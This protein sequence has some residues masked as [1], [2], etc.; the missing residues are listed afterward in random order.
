V[1]RQAGSAT[2]T[3]MSTQTTIGIIGTGISG[4]HLA[5][6]L[7][8]A[9]MGTTVYAAHAPDV[10]AAGRP[11]S[12]MTRFEQTR[13]RERS[14]GVAHW[15]APDHGVFA[16][17]IDVLGQQPLS[18][19][20][21]PRRPASRVDFR[22]Y[23]PKLLADYIARGGSTVVGRVDLD[24]LADRHDLIVIAAGSASLPRLFPCDLAR[25]PYDRPQRR[26]CAGLFH[27]IAPT[28]S[29][30]LRIQLSPRTGEIFANPFRS[31]VGDA[32]VLMVEAVPGG[33]PRIARI[34]LVF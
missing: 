31:P 6:R 27:G 16:I 11:A 28:D 4:L 22:L 20:G 26:L 23:P 10:L 25:S 32:H 19:V 34:Q 1:P 30:G 15:E 5:L 9:G 33:P 18:F 24:R 21:R 17:Q 7:Q 8:Q 14:L 12:F 2:V 29:M 13:A 3:R